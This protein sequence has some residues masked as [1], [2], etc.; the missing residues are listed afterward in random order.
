M[1]Q[2][3]DVPVKG[4]QEY[5]LQKINQR[6]KIAVIIGAVLLAASIVM[7]FLYSAVSAEQLETTM[8]LNQYRLGSMTLTSAVQSYA[9]T[10]SQRY[11]DAYMKELNEDQNRDAAREILRKN[12]LTTEEW[13][14]LNRI[15]SMSEGL[16]PL[17]EDAMAKAG[18]GD[19]QDAIQYVFGDEY[20]E[21]I[22]SI[23]SL[24]DEAI[25]QIQQREMAKAN[26]IKIIQILSQLLFLAS[27]LYVIREMIQTIHFARR[28]LLAPIQEAS[29]Q[30]TALA[31]GNFHQ[32]LNLVEDDTEVGRMA[33]A[34]L[35][36][37]RNL[38]NMIQEIS[39]ILEQ[40]S[41]GNY[42]VS[43]K[44][45]YVGE[46]I[47]IKESLI[48]IT[49]IMRETLTAILNASEQID[50]GSGQLSYAAED[51]AENST[52]Q[53]G[54]VAEL[55]E[56]VS[57]MTADIE[58][59]AQSARESVALSSHAGETLAVGNRKMQEL[60]SAIGNIS[61]CSE[62]IGTIIETIRDIA[63][64]TN[65]LS[66][67]A[68]IEAARAGEAGKG[69]AVVAD[70]VKKLAEESS[71][72]TE[73]TTRLIETTIEAV[74]RGIAIADDTVKSMDE[75]MLG[76]KE[77]TEKMGEISEMLKDDVNN[78]HV[79]NEHITSVSEIVDS[80]AAASEE[81]AAVSSEQKTQVETMV[82]L[83]EKFK[84]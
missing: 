34:M 1:S 40:M 4:G 82:N 37:K 18:S 42:Q 31:H 45:E 46:F 79:F 74:N 75:V 8:A 62:Q 9:V 41:A 53:A 69:F 44:Q 61:K 77:A 20:E 12:H 23:N 52:L 38:V 70:Q 59:N 5:L 71:M 65:L 11:Y 6:T 15:A 55:V 3:M 22:S 54:K 73:E 24:T 17:E 27:F 19:T 33:G 43:I 60:K 30:M 10:G 84:I 35:F 63:S 81:T 25:N 29:R 28:D 49:E 67:N 26:T 21:T 80:N 78:M 13:D 32:E 72:A 51:L 76:A 83:L 50:S 57:K 68:A 7:T 58:R 47:Q 2:K 56:L 39:G 36:M 14:K 66:L 48:K 16:V 64:Q